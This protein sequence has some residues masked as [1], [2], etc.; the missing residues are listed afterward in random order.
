MEALRASIDVEAFF[1]RLKGAASQAL[2]LDYDGTLAPFCVNPAEARP[3]PG[4]SA[5]LDQIMEAGTRVVI[6]SGRWT[7]DLVPLLGLKRLPEIWG[8]H[9]FERLKP[10][11]AYSLARVDQAALAALAEADTWEAQLA[12]LGARLEHKPASLAIHWRGLPARKIQEIR[13]RIEEKGAAAELPASLAWHEFDG[14]IE[15]RVP[16]RDKG[17]AVAAVFEE[18]GKGIAAAYLGDDQTDEDAFKALEGKGLRVLVRPQLRPTG[19]DLWIRPPRELL[20]FLRQWRD[21]CPRRRG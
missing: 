5:L 10:D 2:L 12:A 15:L 16:G 20:R 18:M 8:C 3:Y 4:V 1:E 19:A 7:C 11:G 17:H 14:G 6:V 13:R 21:A 9:G